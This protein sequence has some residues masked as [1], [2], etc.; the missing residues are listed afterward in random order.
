VNWVLH[1]F[2]LMRA[3]HWT[4]RRPFHYTYIERAEIVDSCNEQTSVT[5]AS[6]LQTS[7]QSI[8]DAAGK[9]DPV[10]SCDGMPRHAGA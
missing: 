2:G 10:I 5:T 8:T 1:D 4:V 7:M 9:L 6:N 3:I